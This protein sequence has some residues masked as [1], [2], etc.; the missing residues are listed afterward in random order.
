MHSSLKI[1]AA[2]L[3]LH[4]VT[5]FA[6]NESNPITQPKQNNCH[7]YEFIK[8]SDQRSDP[9]NQAAR[10]IQNNWIMLENDLARGHGETLTYLRNLA[11]CPYVLPS[12][13]WRD[14][15]KGLPYLDRE[16]KFSKLF[17]SECLCNR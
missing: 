4:S 13:L 2:F 10:F 17:F 9:A 11:L 6:E 5:T 12:N 1:T 8:N 16:P 14:Q 3:L 7:F 15:L